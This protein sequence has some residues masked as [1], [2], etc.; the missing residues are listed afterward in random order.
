MRA[1]ALRGRRWIGTGGR[2]VG[3]AELR[4]RVVLL[5]FWTAGC[6]NCLR[7][8]DELA[9]LEDRH[10]DALVV[11]GVHSPKFPHEAEPAAVDAAVRRH[12]VRHPVLDDADLVTWDAF[13]ARAW[14]TSVLVD[15][16]GY[17]VAQATGEG[18]GPELS[19]LVDELVAAEGDALRRGPLFADDG[20]GLRPE[21]HVHDGTRDSGVQDDAGPL[22]FPAKVAVLPGATLLVSDSG[23]HRLVELESDAQTVRRVIGDGTRGLR[24]GSPDTAR[25]AEPLGVL[26]LP[27]DVADAVGYDVLVADSGN[28]VLRGVRLADGD[29]SVVAGTGAQSRVRMPVGAAGPAQEVPLS[30][31][32][33]VTWWDGRVVVAMAGCHQ[34]WS[35]D[36]VAGT[37]SATICWVAASTV[38]MTIVALSWVGRNAR[39]PRPCPD[40]AFASSGIA[41]RPT[42]PLAS[43]G[44]P[45][46][47]ASADAATAAQEKTIAAAHQSSPCTIGTK[48]RLATSTVP[49]AVRHE[50]IT[51]EPHQRRMSVSRSTRPNASNVGLSISQ[52]VLVVS[53]FG[54]IDVSKAHSSGI[55]QSS[56]NATRTPKQTRLNRRSR[57]S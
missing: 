15:P 41:V 9:E 53:A 39:K 51:L 34:L 24:D 27:A 14:P 26:V 56:E 29:V 12:G 30:T 6:V 52:V 46:Q 33:D 42:S 50:M 21:G 19:A 32:W 4:G 18:H 54:L 44:M 37:V 20:A 55:S 11:L 3:P 22:R 7:V 5:D 17:V 16:R 48:A 57:L 2:E 28:H 40:S 45:T 43:G 36:P 10:G 38:A 23:H 8:L 31:P 35:F 25:F 47:R 1:P 49:M 13:A